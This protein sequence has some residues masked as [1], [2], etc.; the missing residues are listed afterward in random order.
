M[1]DNAIA[2][3]PVFLLE[4]RDLIA[5]AKL[6]IFSYMHM[7]LGCS[8]KINIIP[9]T[10]LHAKTDIMKSLIIMSSVILIEKRAVSIAIYRV[11]VVITMSRRV[12]KVHS[13]I[14]DSCQQTE[15]QLII[16]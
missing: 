10:A 6:Q 2:A 8:L 15:L 16:D 4:E 14:Y 11:I 12:I 13:P 1:E 5:D 7:S 9:Y 3:C